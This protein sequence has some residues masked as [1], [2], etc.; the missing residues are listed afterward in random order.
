MMFSY[1]FYYFLPI[2]LGVGLYFSK[3]IVEFDR[4]V[5]ASSVGFYLCYFGFIFFPVEGPRFA[6]ASFHQIELKGF[7]FSPLAQYV[8]KVAGLHGGC[9]PSSHCTLAFIVLVYSFR[10]HKTIFYILAPLILSLFVATVYGRFHYAS[11]VFIGILVA[12]ICIPICDKISSNWEKRQK[13]L[14]F[15][16]ELERVEIPS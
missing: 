5:F 3:K 13:A 1:F 2:I 14:V 6:L 4:F 12:I 16:E 10:Y 7:I 15:E 8:I 9:M 11:D